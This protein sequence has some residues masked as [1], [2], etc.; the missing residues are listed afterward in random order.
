MK[1]LL[2]FLLATIITT[3]TQTLDKEQANTPLIPRSV[4]FGLDD[5]TSKTGVRI[6]PDGKQLSYLAP[7]NKVLNLFIRS[8]QTDRTAQQL[9]FETKKHIASYSWLYDNKHICYLQDHDGDE[10][11][12]LFIIDVKTK[13]TQDL[14]PYPG[15]KV[16]GLSAD[17]HRPYE[18]L[19]FMNKENPALFDVYKL[20]IRQPNILEKLTSNTGL[21]ENWLI[22]DNWTIRG[23]E[24]MNPEGGKE[25][26]I[27]SSESSPYEKII[28]WDF[29]DQKTSGII[30]FC[31]NDQSLYIIDSRD[32]NTG[33]LKKL[34]L[35]TGTEET[36]AYD[37]Q[38]E[39]GAVSIHP[40][41]KKIIAYSLEKDKSE[42]VIFDEEFKK[43]YDY[44]T[45]IEEGELAIIS[46]TADLSLWICCY[47]YDNK[48]HNYYLYDRSQQKT[49]LLFASS[50]KFDNYTLVH[51]EPITFTSRD[52]LDIHGYLTLPNE[53]TK[54]LPL[55]LFVHGGPQLHDTW[56]LDIT[57]Q[58]F[59]NRG[60]AVLQIN[61]RGSTGYGKAFVNAGNKEWGGKMHDD[62]IDAVNWA[63][64]TGIADPQKIAIYGGSYGGYAA[65]A[66]VT[67]TPDVFCCAVDIVGPSNLLTFMNTIPAYWKPFIE[68]IHKRIGNPETEAEF[69]KERSP[70]FHVQSI[71]KPLFIAQGTN[72]PRVNK[73]EA[74][75]IVEA[76]K[77]NNCEYEYMVFDDE[78]HGFTKH[79]NKMLFHAAAEKFLAKHLG[80]RCER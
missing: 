16:A 25:V 12:H 78:G 56:G 13:Q 53:Q 32:A 62:L 59:A 54:N 31:D 70:L 67:F 58:W 72:D 69:L 1:K 49:T 65:L 57:A 41:T 5:P 63:I 42:P 33:K 75:Q 47:A 43:D 21:V 74:D 64:N 34:S 60:Y 14:T 30:D 11:H 19:I 77:K 36:I 22:D 9:T 73:A 51:M 3:A 27:R 4:L 40:D 68:D 76:L 10:N 61:Y 39:I 24:I 79:E 2:L 17:K 45:T 80:G 38:Y 26:W 37:E 15:V 7:V 46:T 28:E 50:H 52:G 48:L 23:M 29:E 71:K 44:L 18:L 6:S 66:G 55:I 8:I 35:T 20:D